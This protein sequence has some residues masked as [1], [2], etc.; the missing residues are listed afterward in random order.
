MKKPALK[1]ANNL[2]KQKCTELVKRSRQETEKGLIT[3]SAC[4]GRA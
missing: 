2:P 4:V 3:P 1:K